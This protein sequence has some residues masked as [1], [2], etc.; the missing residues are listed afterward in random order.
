MLSVR[1]SHPLAALSIPA[2][3]LL[4]S[5]LALNGCGSGNAPS[6]GGGSG[7]TGTSAQTSTLSNTVLL[8]Y[9]WNSADRSIHSIAGVPGSSYLG[10]I[11]G[12]ASTYTSAAISSV[13]NLALAQDGKGNLILIALPSG[14]PQ[15]VLTSLSGIAQVVFSRGG[16]YAA[17]WLPGT[18]KAWLLQQLSSATPSATAVMT[19]GPV[20]GAAVSDQG[21]VL[22]ATSAQG[23]VQVST[24]TASGAGAS[25][26]LLGGY[27]GMAFVHGTDN[28]VIADRRQDVASLA[29]SVSTKPTVQTL[30]APAQTLVQPVAVE[31][32]TDGRWALLA[33]GGEQ[34]IARFDLTGATTAAKT[35]LTFTPAQVLPLVGN[36]IFALTTTGSGPT[37]IVDATAAAPRVLF[38]PAPSTG[39]GSQ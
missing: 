37:W 6:A 10:R 22:T 2:V 15:T 28:A 30:A 33:N 25:I 1:N 39:A 31:I 29:Q 21:I 23:G 19:A 36:G 9:I 12:P 27:G 20:I 17:V 16:Q 8:G 34:S 32:S 35:A 11:V 3:V 26:L 7:G 24:A 4:V 5:I 38:I 13:A 14:A 18:K